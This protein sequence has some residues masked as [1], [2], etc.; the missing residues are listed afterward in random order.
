MNTLHGHDNMVSWYRFFLLFSINW[1]TESDKAY[2]T[3][4]LIARI[5]TFTVKQPG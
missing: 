4:R 5:M 1:I 3:S 2:S